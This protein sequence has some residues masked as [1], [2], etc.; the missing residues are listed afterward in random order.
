LEFALLGELGALDL[1]CGQSPMCA[2]HA[3]MPTAWR[4]V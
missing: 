3:A 1:D 2:D 4:A